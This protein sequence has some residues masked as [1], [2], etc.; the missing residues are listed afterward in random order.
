M[1]RLKWKILQE[2]YSQIKISLYYT[3]KFHF[4]NSRFS[5]IGFGELRLIKNEMANHENW[6]WAAENV[7]FNDKTMIR[8]KIVRFFVFICDEKTP[9]QTK[10]E[11]RTFTK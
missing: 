6:K 11:R 2:S 1:E 5:F 10:R 9:L 8:M 4:S 3:F 7:A